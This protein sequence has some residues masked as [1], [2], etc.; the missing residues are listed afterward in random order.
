VFLHQDDQVFL[1]VTNASG[2]AANHLQ[3]G[4]DRFNGQRTDGVASVTNGTI[5]AGI[6]YG[7]P[8][9][10]IPQP[11]YYRFWLHDA[12]GAEGVAGLAFT[13]VAISTLGGGYPRFCHNMVK[14]LAANIGT[15]GQMR[16]MGQSILYANT[17]PDA[18][19]SGYIAGGQVPMNNFWM[20]MITN[21]GDFTSKDI[22]KGNQF[23]ANEG[24][25][26]W[27]K[28][29][30]EECLTGFLN[31]HKLYKGQVIEYHPPLT[32]RNDYLMVWASILAPAT[33]TALNPQ[34]GQV[35]FA[36]SIEY[37]STDTWKPRRKATLNDAEAA[38]F[39]EA[40]KHLGNVQQFTHNP[41]H[42]EVLWNA[43]KGGVRFVEEVALPAFNT[44]STLSSAFA[45]G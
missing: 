28:P 9:L 22:A 15:T 16:I 4:C 8:T 26:G 24:L 12:S 38:M 29:D 36:S 41:N 37:E 2:V 18:G 44:F 42:L 30:R 33:G 10:T 11:G 45:G 39:T 34:G 13:S 43:L 14:D 27:L 20:S 1:L 32:H 31:Y 19:K 23:P 35:T 17:A 6:A 40:L 25:Y 21:F 7:F 3:F 5:T